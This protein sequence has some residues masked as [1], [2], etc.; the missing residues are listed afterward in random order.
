MGKTIWL[1]KEEQL[2]WRAYLEGTQ[3]LFDALERQLMRD[4]GLS[5]ADYEILVHLS[6]STD[7]T[8]RMSELAD[9]TLYSRSRLSHAVARLEQPGWVVREACPTDRRGTLARLTP[10]G[11]EKLKASAPGHAAEVRRIIFDNL[12]PAQTA[13]LEAIGAIIREGAGGCP[14]AS[15]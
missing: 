14:A 10:E 5:H 6:E 7:H 9:R 13:Q 11:F 15:T 4:A 1:T 3:L 2:A 8:L 12:T